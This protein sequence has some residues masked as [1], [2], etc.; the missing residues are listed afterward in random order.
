[1]FDTFN[2]GFCPQCML[3]GNLNEML[4]NNTDFF[5]CPECRLQVAFNQVGVAIMRERGNGKLKETKA[6]ERYGGVFLY[7]ESNTDKG[8]ATHIIDSE[9]K[10][11]EYLEKEVVR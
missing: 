6:T 10:L 8:V 4:L 5:E 9:A 2:D 1:M 3:G 11:R 7:K